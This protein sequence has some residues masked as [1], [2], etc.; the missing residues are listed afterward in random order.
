MNPKALI[1]AG[2]RRR[3]WRS[4]LGDHQCVLGIATAFKIGA[5]LTDEWPFR[6]P[7]FSARRRIEP[8]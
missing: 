8:N 7:R 2:I 6:V 3:D 5:G 4:G 1:G